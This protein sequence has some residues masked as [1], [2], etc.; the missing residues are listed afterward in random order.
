MQTEE[1][2]HDADRQLDRLLGQATWA[3][4]GSQQVE[5]LR[6][7]WRRLAGRRRAR[8]VYAGLALAASVLLAA[9]LAWRHLAPGPAARILAKRPISAPITTSHD[10][11]SP[12]VS[13]SE[14]APSLPV[15]DLVAARKPNEYER[16]ILAQTFG[17]PAARRKPKPKPPTSEEV[18]ETLL[19]DEIASHSGA[20]DPTAAREEISKL[21]AAPQTDLPGI[22][23]L[24]WEVIAQQ[25]DDR[26]QAAVRLLAQV[27]TPRSAP[28]LVELARNPKTHEVAVLGLARLASN[29][30]LARLA[31]GERDAALGRRLMGMLLA[32]NTPDAVVRYLELVDHR[33]TRREALWALR[34]MDDPPVDLLFGFLDSPQERP[35]L[36]AALALAQLGDPE[37]AR[38]LSAFVYRDTSRQGALAALLLSRSETANRF[39][40]V[41]RQ[42]LYL[43]AAV[44]AAEF[45]IHSLTEP[46]GGKQP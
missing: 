28:L 19:A 23:T 43:V 6:R 41:A 40:N 24:L 7:Q 16:V 30:E 39:L 8:R 26:R 35:R 42:D 20:A 13:P 4:P 33:Q 46:S 38:R 34:E 22:E 31:A 11:E 45:E 3:E 32:R 44:R 17:R 18:L 14:Q 37:V 1:P 25:E 27:A 21:L 10:V 15:A 9:T 5:R 2:N 36:S 12:K 29:D